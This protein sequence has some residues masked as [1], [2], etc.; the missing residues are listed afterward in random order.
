MEAESI[1]QTAPAPIEIQIGAEVEQSSLRG[2]QINLFT[3]EIESGGATPAG[4]QG[5]LFDPHW[6]DGP[7]QTV[8]SN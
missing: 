5:W 3:G 2:G 1:T 6:N 4:I 8:K 7:V